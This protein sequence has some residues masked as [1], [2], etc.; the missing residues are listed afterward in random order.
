MYS[1]ET[2]ANV[3]TATPSQPKSEYLYARN[4]VPG[5]VFF[6]S[7]TKTYW[8]VSEDENDVSYLTNLSTGFT[9]REG[10]VF[11]YEVD[12]GTRVVIETVEAVDA[13]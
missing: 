2:V 1:K 11:G 4:Y 9:D 6:A 10:H 5:S 12:P 8:I 7:A 3:I 13:K